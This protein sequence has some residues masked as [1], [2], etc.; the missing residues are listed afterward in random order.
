MRI[1]E[2]PKLYG[3]RNPITGK[4]ILFY[5]AS[6]QKHKAI[7]STREKAMDAARWFDVEPEI[8]EFT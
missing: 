3:L 1:S 8:V 4:L 6:S 7:F 5:W 2:Y